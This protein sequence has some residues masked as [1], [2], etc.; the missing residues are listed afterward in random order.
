MKNKDD[1]AILEDIRVEAIRYGITVTPEEE[2]VRFASLKG[3]QTKSDGSAVYLVF[4]NDAAANVVR[5]LRAVLKGNGTD[6]PEFPPEYSADA[7]QIVTNLADHNLKISVADAKVRKRSS[8]IIYKGGDF[9]VDMSSVPALQEAREQVKRAEKMLADMN[10]SYAET[11]SQLFEGKLELAA[12]PEQEEAIEAEPEMTVQ[13]EI[14]EE[15]ST[16]EDVSDEPEAE[17]E[18]AIEPEA[19]DTPD[20]QEI[21]SPEN[22]DEVSFGGEPDSDVTPKEVDLNLDEAPVPS[23][24]DNAPADEDDAAMTED[25]AAPAD[26]DDSPSQDHEVKAEDDNAPEPA[27]TVRPRP[28]LRVGA[29]RTPPSS[30]PRP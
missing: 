19:E 18:E 17:Q 14:S 26:E 30:G 4:Y 2:E 20:E 16:K 10:S 22:T 8:G 21:A 6:T 11:V 12:S 29:R 1:F 7:N 27:A 15:S 28:R 23:E 3:S 25:D 5:D 24:D 9:E 13:E